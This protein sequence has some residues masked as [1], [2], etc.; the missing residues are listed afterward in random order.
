MTN[1]SC[2]V[3]LDIMK[4]ND[5]SKTNNSIE[6]WHLAFARNVEDHPTLNKLIQRLRIDQKNTSIL[7]AQ[8]NAGD[9]YEQ[10]AKLKTVQDNIKIL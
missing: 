5:E 9:Y 6:A 2:S 3:F 10:K 4:P 8:L 7:L 1:R